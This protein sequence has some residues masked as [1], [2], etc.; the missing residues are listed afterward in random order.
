MKQKR[1]KL[2]INAYRRRDL[3]YAGGIIMKKKGRKIILWLSMVLISF[4]FLYPLLWMVLT[5]L[6]TKEDVMMNPFGL[7]AEWMFSNY[8]DAFTYDILCDHVCLCG[9]QNEI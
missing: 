2:L 9:C 6:K 1:F 5:S 3:R 7:P 8:A 4:L